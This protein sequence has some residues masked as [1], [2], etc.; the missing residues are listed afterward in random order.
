MLQQEP[1]LLLVLQTCRM[2][3]SD[4]PPVPVIH[5]RKRGLLWEEVMRM[6]GDQGVHRV[7]VSSS[8]CFCRWR[9]CR[10]V[11]QGVPFLFDRSSADSAWVGE[12]TYDAHEA[13]WTQNN[14][15]DLER[16]GQQENRLPKARPE[17]CPCFEKDTFS[18]HF[19]V[20]ADL[21]MLYG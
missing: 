6:E 3:G 12:W 7:R 19:I 17:H 8:C 4:F 16:Q 21:L 5:S 11:W 20:F 9:G 13:D 14:L 15:R 10:F 2:K 18:S 1:C